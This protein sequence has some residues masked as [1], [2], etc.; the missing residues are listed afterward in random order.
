M[1]SPERAPRAGRKIEWFAGPN[2]EPVSLSPAQIL[3]LETTAKDGGNTPKETARIL[4]VAQQTVRTQF[5]R[6]GAKLGTR[7]WFASFM[8]FQ[9]HR[10]A[11]ARQL[12]RSK[13][14]A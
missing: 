9:E 13:V 2:G 1:P 3:I 10:A 5:G 4:G 14:E 6:I 7:H 12:E 11:Q 8:R